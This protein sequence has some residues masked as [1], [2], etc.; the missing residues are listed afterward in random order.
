MIK[1]LRDGNYLLIE[2]RTQTKILILDGIDTFA[3]VSPKEIGELLVISHRRHKIDHILAK[4]SYK[5]YKVEDEKDF[6]DQIHLE[7][8]VGDNMWQ[9]Y[10]LLSGLPTDLK[11][12]VRIVPTMELLTRTVADV[13]RMHT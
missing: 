9:G 5:L 8:S 6:V 4:G 7:L 3:W 13:S 1:L 2:T 12:R 11:K 10:L